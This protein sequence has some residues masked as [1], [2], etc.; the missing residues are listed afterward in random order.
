MKILSVSVPEKMVSEMDAIQKSM[1]FSGRSELIRA[2]VRGLIADN[3]EKS[4][5]SGEV[6]AIIVATHDQANEELVT[7]LKHTFEDI[8]KT[9]LHN[10]LS[11]RS[12]AELFLVQGDGSKIASMAGAF[13]KDE[14]MKSVK[15]VIV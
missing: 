14:G 10:K 12:C 5:I 4:G 15:M 7:K 2:A 11:R 13:Q 6:N 9:H 8:V 3:R 1:G